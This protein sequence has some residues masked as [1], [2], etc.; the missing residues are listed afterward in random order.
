MTENKE[1][2]RKINFSQTSYIFGVL[3]LITAFFTPL[4]GLVIGIVGL[5][6]SRREK[7]KT[8]KFAMKLSIA[9]IIVSIVIF[10]VTFILI[11]KSGALPSL[12]L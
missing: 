4:L 2:E 11:S 9:G 12:P 7:T 3:S 6:Q 8:S 1:A 5:V 10:V